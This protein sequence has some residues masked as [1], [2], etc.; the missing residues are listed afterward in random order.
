[1]RYLVAIVLLFWL[2]P[3]VFGQQLFVQKYP[4][5]VYRGSDQT[6]G[7]AQDKD[8]MIYAAESKGVLQFNGYE[9]R[10]IPI[11]DNKAVYSLAFDSQ[12][13]LYVGS[14]KELGYLQKDGRGI[15]RYH[16]LIDRL[17][18][19][20]RNFRDIGQ[21]IVIRDTVFFCNG[22]YVF[23]YAH[24]NFT[25]FPA[26]A[27]QLLLLKGQL[28][29]WDANGFHVYKDTAFEESP[30]TKELEGIKVWEIKGFAGNSWLLLDDHNKLW[31]F[32][33]DA[34]PGRR[35]R[36][37]LN[38]SDR[39]FKDFRIWD[40]A[41]LDNGKVMVY[42]VK[43][44]FFF[45]SDGQLSNVVSKEMLGTDLFYGNFYQDAHHNIWLATVSNIFHILTNS[46]LSYY[47]KVNGF[48][49]RVVSLG[50]SG[51]DRYVGTGRG[52]FHEEDTGTFSAVP[53][54]EGIAWNFY[55]FHGKLYV[56]SNKGVLE[57][58]GKT[59]KKIIDQ[60][61][62]Q[63]LCELNNDPDHLLMG[64][65]NS[66][67][68]LLEKKGNGWIKR[69]IRGFEEWARYL[70]QD[71]AGYIWIGDGRESIF[72]ARLN[73]RMDSVIST[74]LY[75]DKKGLPAGSYNRPYRRPDGEVVITTVD[76]IYKYDPGKDRFQPILPFRKA[77]GPGTYINSMVEDSVGN[78]YFRSASEQYSEMAGIL[79]RQPDGNFT[80]LRTPFNKIALPI[81]GFSSEEDPIL[82][83]SPHEVW[84]G[85]SEKLVS[86]DPSPEKPLFDKPLHLIIEQV[87][88]KDS[89]IFTGGAGNGGLKRPLPFDS[90]SLR[91]RFT[92]SDL[93]NPEKIE[94]QYRLE[95]FE[96]SWSSWVPDREAVFTNLSEADY[97][98]RARA[99]NQ[100]GKVSNIESF[101]FRILPPLYRS[102]WAYLLYLVVFI[103]FVYGIVRMNEK[104]IKEKNR[105]LERKV[106]ERTMELRASHEKVMEQNKEIAEQAKVLQDLNMTKDKLFSIISHDLRG[107]IS[108]ILTTIDVMKR[109]GLS[110]QEVM[111]F[112][113]EL[114]DH[115][116]VTGHLL[117]NLLF[118][119][120]AQMD[121]FRSIP[122]VFDVKDVV[123][124]NCRL[125]RAL[126]DGKNIRLINKTDS[127]LW[128]FAD[129]DIVTMVLRNLINNAIKFTNRGGEITIGNET[130]KDHVELFVQDTGTGLS[131]GDISKILNKQSFHRQDTSGQLG[132]GLGL[133]L[134]QELIEK[135][136]GKIAIES[137]AGKGSRFSFRVNVFKDDDDAAPP[138][139]G[140]RIPII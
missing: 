92:T 103:F 117:N 2:C 95:G 106:G 130:D 35:F 64:T 98:I 119:A 71:S 125:F 82:I 42:S 89:L 96:N 138:G 31:I 124:E 30:L 76:G 60:E 13:V 61:D 99:R 5:E 57:L 49:G 9:W 29:L 47:D 33:P 97:T 34:L 107:P 73:T 56:A 36:L 19:T 27:G 78:I 88:V 110:E 55:N 37:F 43:G 121:G 100:Y 94:Y 48:V 137:H 127:S 7:F 83:V 101:T 62:V 118:W 54:T 67:I 74:G 17:P 59:A 105:E 85:A 53:G 104:R 15:S 10:L 132:S 77:L 70:Q 63:S 123:E 14:Y 32:D 113:A 72:R 139:R 23:R 81:P 126:A 46:P 51:A 39:Y 135:E 68:F 58:S 44:L 122:S 93:E 8:G 128:V 112:S 28:T 18:A 80:A 84:I 3:T 65:I 115:M 12:D 66:G 6:Y 4:R 79:N 116:M 131:G 11:A 91:F 52:I 108:I 136:G 86:Y 102:R 38:G 26:K 120:K 21:I 90:N 45:T 111:S 22:S 41:Y 133:M 50:L 24:N 20:Y 140:A 40:M 109:G 114:G 129:K 87:S 75:D 1:M 134:C 16:S 69:K 25:I